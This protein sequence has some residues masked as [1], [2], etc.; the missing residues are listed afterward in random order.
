MGLIAI[1]GERAVF[2]CYEG[3]GNDV[4]K[5]L[6]TLIVKPALLS[7]IQKLIINKHIQII[8]ISLEIE[9]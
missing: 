5:Q 6:R 8:A 9:R 4:E 1:V 7:N 3:K 2:V